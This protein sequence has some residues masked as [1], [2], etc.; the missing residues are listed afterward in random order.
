MCVLCCVVLCCVFCLC[1]CQFFTNLK[2]LVPLGSNKLEIPTFLTLVAHQ[3]AVQSGGD[4]CQQVEREKKEKKRGLLW[5]Q[6]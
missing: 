2:G 4:G 5:V 6:K 3:T 1:V